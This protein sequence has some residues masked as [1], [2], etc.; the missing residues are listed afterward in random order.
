MSRTVAP[1]AAAGSRPIRHRAVDRALTLLFKLPPPSSDYA[2][3][4]DLRVRMRDGVELLA[5]HYAPAGAAK[6]TLVLRSPYGW[7]FPTGPGLNAAPYAARGYH[8]VLVRCRGTFGS[9]GAFE[10]MVHEVDDSA[11]TVAWLREQPWFDGRFATLGA[12]YLGFTQWALLMEPPAELATA[13]IQ[14]G[15]HDFSRA[16]YGTG[17]FTL[18][19]AL[20][21]SELVAHQEAHGLIRGLARAVTAERRV[22]PAIWSLPA[23]DAAERLC[24]G[25][26]PWYREW[27]SHRDLDDPFWAPM[28]LGEALDRVRV[29]VLLHA[30][31]QDIFLRQTVEQYAHLRRRGT[32]V[33]LTVGPWTHVDVATRAAAMLTRET[34]EWLDLHLAGAGGAART[35][36]VR[37][38]VTGAGQ[39]RDL[40]DWPNAT[41]GRALYPQFGGGLDVRPAPSGTPPA[42]FT[43]DPA[44][45]TPTIGGRMLSPAAG[46]YKDDSALA[47]RTDVLA[48]TTAPLKRPVEVV[49]V[50]VV[51]LA[52]ASDNPHADVFVRISEVDAKGRSRNLTDGFVRLH[53]GDGD[54]MVRVE[55]DPVAHRFTARNRIRLLIAGGSFP[56]WERN[57]GTDED[58][59][60]SSAMA[61][62]HRTVDLTASRVVLPMQQ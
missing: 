18:A 56:R 3:T 9:G 13:V 53:P 47:G 26:A 29:P 35:T 40:P 59:A 50:P 1:A 6:G 45:P 60:T 12:S 23:A 16:L 54:G 17:A 22:A 5:D 30:G 57:L 32:D 21:W 55:L 28:R 62:S 10:P 46:G 58:P 61:P 36:P 48:F 51:E 37:M 52:H 14:V 7:R 31:W 4:R 8:V 43:Y 27:L 15:P 39:W 38:F 34:L 20:G 42:T 11:D 44:E 25:R 2:I 49:G 41:V 24:D 33:A 19:N